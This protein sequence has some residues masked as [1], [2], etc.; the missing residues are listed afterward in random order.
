[1]TERARRNSPPPRLRPLPAGRRPATAR[2]DRRLEHA[3]HQL[4]TQGLNF[5]HRHI[6]D[7]AVRRRYERA[8]R[9]YADRVRADVLAGRISVEEGV[10]NANQVRN[11]I[12]E[13]AR[14]RT[15][16]VGR[17][18]AEKLKS[19]GRT[20]PELRERYAEKTFG[21]PFSELSKAQRN[22]VDLELIEAS[23]RPSK[24]ASAKVSRL[25]RL[26][27]GVAVLSFGI[28]VYN[29][30]M[31]EDKAR[32]ATR[33]ATVAGGGVAGGAAG[34][35]LAGLA[36]GPGAPVCVTVGV[37]VGGALGALGVDLFWELS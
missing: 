32:Q 37:F 15:S 35:A 1:V 29:V 18:R 36:C 11:Q 31:A 19:R 10:R 12:M 4:Q 17:A 9:A 16:D 2:E 24:V 30:A 6:R 21:K 5:A 7:D 22:R 27:R 20:L 8:I 23:G 14:L 25:A 33:E 13:A 3:L 28:A 26:G 34:G